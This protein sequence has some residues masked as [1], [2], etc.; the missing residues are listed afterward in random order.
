MD[1]Q[2]LK[3]RQGWSLAKKIDH[4][5]LV[6]ETF[7]SRTK[8]M[9]YVAFSGGKDSTALLDLVRIIDKTIPAVFVNTGNEWPDIIKFVRHLRDDKGYNI[10]EI[11]PKMRPYQVWQKYGFP[12]VSKSCSQGLYEIDHARDKEKVLSRIREAREKGGSFGMVSQRWEW[13]MDE[14]FKVSHLC[15]KMLKKDPSHNYTK[16]TGRNPILGT[17]A[18]ESKLRMMSYVQTGGCNSFGENGE[19]IKS[20]PLAIWMEDD[21]WAYIKD[22]NLEIAEIYHKGVDRTGCV[23]CG[24][25]IYVADD[26]RFDVLYNLEPRYYQ[27]IMNYT[28]NG[29]TYREAVRKVLAVTGKEL[30]DENGRI[31]FPDE[32]EKS[33]NRVYDVEN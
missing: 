26:Q 20:T 29:H 16:E 24:F 32:F 9:C 13:L 8:G 33:I 15:C 30:P 10:Q 2:E 27:A 31:Y 18:S 11:H 22:R 4:S 1:L 25:G 12:L 17:M 19:K 14:P 6:I 23:G 21:V 5:L 3:E 28:N 7:I